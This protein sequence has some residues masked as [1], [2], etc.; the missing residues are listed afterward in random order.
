MATIYD[1]SF[2]QHYLMVIMQSSYFYLMK[3]IF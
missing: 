2:L 3:I 1:P